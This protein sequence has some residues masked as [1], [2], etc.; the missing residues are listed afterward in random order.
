[1]RSLFIKLLFLSTVIGLAVSCADD[2][3]DEP[4]QSNGIVSFENPVEGKAVS[5]YG[6][7]ITLTVYTEAAYTARLDFIS[8][9]GE[10]AELYRGSTGTLGRN[11]IRIIFDP[12]ET[13]ES[14]S[15]ELFIQ[16]DGFK[17]VS[18]VVFEQYEDGMSASVEKNMEI[19]T[20]M[21]DILK[22]DYLWASSYAGLDVDLEMD[23]MQFLY[24]H[25]TKLGEE[26]IED[27]GYAKAYAAEPG[28][29][30]IYSYISE[31][32]TVQTKAVSTLGLGLGP[33]FSSDVSVV[34]NLPSGSVVGL[35]IAY[36]HQGSPADLAGLRRGD[37]IFMVNGT[38]V[39]S[40]NY[41]TYMSQLYSSPSGSYDFAFLRFDGDS[42]P[43]EYTVKGVATGTYVYNPVLY[44]TVMVKD[45]HKIGY[46]ALETFDIASQEIL[47][48][49]LEQ[50]I[51]KGITDLILDLRFNAGGSVA[52]SRY[53]ANAIAGRAHDSDTFVKVTYNDGTT[54]DWKFSHGYSN[55][56]D[57]LGKAPDLGIDRLYVIGSYN[58]AS[59]SELIINGLR[60]IDFPVYLYGGQTEGKNV[61][62]TATQ[63]TSGSRK[64]EFAPI[65]F[66]VRNAKDFGDYPDGFKVDEGCEVNNQNA[67]TDDDADNLFP[68]SFG[69]WTDFDFNIAL[70]WVYYDIIGEAR[71]SR[72]KVRSSAEIDYA[73]GFHPM[74][75]GHIERRAGHWGNVIRNNN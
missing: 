47:E 70:S 37:T 40:N 56:T 59:A 18:L 7:T 71:P 15:V 29:R 11:T 45:E 19:N 4:L 51:E 13:E 42:K 10:W 3:G 6:E 33:I 36:V 16:V 32:E 31:V 66:R 25:L 73:D 35:S 69:D 41:K 8:G 58:T 9:E 27:G 75:A 67:S 24:T 72:T 23:Y 52:Q 34:W 5:P 30:F 12:N 46:L 22:E 44:Q 64:Y 2:K 55:D 60:G 48:Y 17:E 50:F 49:A 14:R 28:A 68:Y 20:Y 39:T 1:M 61:G 21:H 26:N 53:L 57:N 74:E 62:M 65:T 63:F 54:E 38:Q 43:T